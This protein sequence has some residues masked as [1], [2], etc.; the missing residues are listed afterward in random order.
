MKAQSNSPA[1]KKSMETAYAMQDKED[2]D[3]YTK[4]QQEYTAAYTQWQSFKDAHLLLKK[5]LQHYLDLKKTVNYNATVSNWQFTD[6]EYQQKS[7]E[8]KL[9]FR[10]GNHSMTT[11]GAMYSSGWQR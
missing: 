4:E 8:W 6:N 10:A 7:S 5:R 9:I 3:Q 11:H 1:Y 2:E